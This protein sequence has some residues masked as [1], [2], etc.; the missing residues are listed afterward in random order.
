M[1][2][3]DYKDIVRYLEN[4]LEDYMDM[5]AKS[6]LTDQSL[7]R[8]KCFLSAISKAE[9][10][11]AMRDEG[12]SGRNYRNDGEYSSGH[13]NRAGNGGGSWRDSGGNGGY[14][15]G[16]DQDEAI[17]TIENMM[18]GERDERRRET[19]QEIVNKMRNR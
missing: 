2:R 3:Q 15:Q 6:D 4:Q 11:V 7:E 17:R 9:T 10:I 12:Y 18:K 8:I 14:S 5:A 13:D 1:E 19:M 16:R